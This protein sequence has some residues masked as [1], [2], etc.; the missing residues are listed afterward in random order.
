MPRGHTEKGLRYLD[1][2]NNL[3]KYLHLINN[4]LF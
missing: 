3:R 2:Y 4:I 1:Y